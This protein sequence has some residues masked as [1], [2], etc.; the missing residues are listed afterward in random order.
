M[1]AVSV[2][3]PYRN[4]AQF[5]PGFVLMLQRQSFMDWIC[6]LVDDQSTDHSA[7][8]AAQ[9]VDGDDRFQLLSFSGTK[10]SPG[11]A[12]VR[13][14]A[15][16]HV[17]TP[18]VA[19]C[20]VDDLWH[21]LKLERQLAFHSSHELDLSVTGYWRFHDACDFP[22][23]SSRCPPEAL[24]YRKLFGGNPIP[25]LSVIV[26][27]DLLKDGMPEIRHEDFAL[28]LDVFR[29]NPGLRYGCLPEGL[30]FYRLHPGSMTSH[31]WKMPFWA[32]AVF[33]RQ[34]LSP[35]GLFQAMLLWSFYQ[36]RQLVLSSQ[37][38]RESSQISLS[39]LLER[40]PVRLRQGV[41]F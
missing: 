23:V 41:L 39:V 3:V 18:L 21:P 36:L 40:P 17:T 38:V 6:F 7:W 33:R 19:F 13:N 5:I 20:D 1:A 12:A 8:I 27:F 9:S 31:R 22:I 34:G 15:L 32:L 25:M 4:G 16:A 10:A 29:T 30:A 35:L 14:F 28:W 2:V 37:V 11:P 26:R 24:S